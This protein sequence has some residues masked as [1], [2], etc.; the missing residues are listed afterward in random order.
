M[1]T[2]AQGN[3]IRGRLGFARQASGVAVVYTRDSICSQLL[4][5]S[6]SYMMCW[7]VCCTDNCKI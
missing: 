2:E 5:R 4:E 1:E 6:S 7:V 3:D